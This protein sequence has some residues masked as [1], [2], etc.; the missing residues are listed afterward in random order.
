[1]SIENV[2]NSLSNMGSTPRSSEGIYNRVSEKT[3]SLFSPNKASNSRLLDVPESLS[4]AVMSEKPDT[5]SA[6]SGS[7]AWRYL[8]IFLILIILAVNL[9]LFLIKPVDT[10]I[11]QMY[12]PLFEFSNRHFSTN[13]KVGD[14]KKGPIV[15]AVS[16]K[17]NKAALKK[18]EKV[19]DEKPL[20]NN[21]D[22][23]NSD[24]LA[25]QLPEKRYKKLPV[26]PQ[27][28]DSMSRTQ[29]NP[30]SK[31]GFCY[32]GEDRGFRSCIEVGEGD[33]CMSGNIFPSEALC[34]NP[35]LRE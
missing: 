1:M 35:N 33:V 8:I 16:K 2:R 10:P 3:G 24:L 17:N 9:I 7:S 28:D 13:F 27:A 15:A 12:D 4:A 29:M 23:Q 14:T 26:I 22:K 34:I 32:I 5:P 30:T 31:S 25:P 6:S 11:S 18:L 20:M 21:I 19:I